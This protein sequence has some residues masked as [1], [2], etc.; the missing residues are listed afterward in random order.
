MK[1]P[2]PLR[3]QKLLPPIGTPTTPTTPP[4]ATPLAIGDNAFISGTSSCANVRPTP[5]GDPPLGCIADASVVTITAGPTDSGG[6]TWWKA[7]TTVGEGWIAAQFLKKPTPPAPQLPVNPANRVWIPQVFQMP[8]FTIERI[9]AAFNPANFLACSEETQSTGFSG[10]P[11]MDYPTSIPEFGVV[12]HADSTPPVDLAL[13]YKYLRDPS[14]SVVG[15]S[16]FELTFSGTT[17]TAGA[18]TVK[19]TGTWIAPF[20]VRTS[21]SWIQVRRAGTSRLMDGGVAIGSDT[22]VVTQKTPRLAQ[23]G[24]DSRLEIVALPGQMAAGKN[25]GTVIIEPLL[26]SGVPYEITITATR[27]AGSGGGAGPTPTPTPVVD[28]YPHKAILPG[29]KSEGSY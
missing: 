17:S 27:P 13:A 23:K 29:L 18:V 3:G 5:G 15:P 4:V 2:P 6:N 28:R 9:A 14:L 8:N 20:R 12:P 25:T 22:D 21:A 10:C 7:T 24:W 1:Y 16:S 26:G 11:T 19:N